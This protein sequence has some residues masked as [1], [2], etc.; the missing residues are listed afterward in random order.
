MKIVVSATSFADVVS[1]TSVADIIEL[2]LDLFSVFPDERKL[3]G[4]E[5]PTIV[6]IRRVQEGGMYKGD[7]RRRIEMLSRYSAYADYV[8]LEC[9]LR[10]E[11]FKAMKCKVIESYHNFKETPN[12]EYLRDLIEGKRGDIFKI[13][14]MGRCKEDVLTITRV[15]CEYDDVVAFLMGENFAWTR[16][17]A[18]FL[19]SPFIYCSI[20]K[21]VAPGQLDARKVRKIFSLLR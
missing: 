9:D 21:A 13:A 11:D 3:L 1:A 5:K 12:Y 18:C 15:L 16:I 17:F 20:S 19:G 2:R 14:T 7:E 4:I 6:T 8:D 10:D